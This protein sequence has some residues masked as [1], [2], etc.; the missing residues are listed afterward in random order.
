M[1]RQF[2]LRQISGRTTLGLPVLRP[3][4]AAFGPPVPPLSHAPSHEVP[5]NQSATDATFAYAP[6]TVHWSSEEALLKPRV[7]S[8]EP[9]VGPRAEH[10][11]HVTDIVARQKDTATLEAGALSP[12]MSQ[13]VSAVDVKPADP[14]KE[15]ARL[16]EPPAA[17]S[18]AANPG[19]PWRKQPAVHIGVIQVNIAAPTSPTPQA[20]TPPPARP[21]RVASP[22]SSALSRGY[23]SSYGLRQ[24]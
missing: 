1:A 2:Y 10:G 8:E 3:R 24:G 7:Q 18:P 20:P 11:P 19:R 13:Q 12:V 6:K 4:F 23:L 14:K 15:M 22:S 17:P 16:P 21:A 5:K 9:L